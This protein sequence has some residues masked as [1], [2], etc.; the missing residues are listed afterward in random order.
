MSYI[1]QVINIY[2][3]GE[4]IALEASLLRLRT[5]QGMTKM[6]RWPLHK[7]KSQPWR[8]ELLSGRAALCAHNT[9][10]SWQPLE[11]EWQR[12]SAMRTWGAV[13]VSWS[14]FCIVGDW[15]DM[16][17]KG[18]RMWTGTDTKGET[19]TDNTHKK[20]CSTSAGTRTCRLKAQ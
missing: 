5:T 3:T 4:G 13:L 6:W 15:T 10:P 7:W 18:K 20:R 19:R 2:W 1:W 16:K 14:T 9:E 8:R 12:S 11:V 17:K